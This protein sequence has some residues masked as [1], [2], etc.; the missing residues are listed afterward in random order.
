M[1]TKENKWCLTA[2]SVQSTS[3]SLEG[4]D[5]VH[6]SDGLSLGV[7]SVGDCI[8]DDI[9]QEHLQH[10]TSLL[11]DETADALHTATT[12]E[13]TDGWLGDSLDVIAKNLP[14]ALGASFSESFASFSTSRHYER[15]VVGL[16][17]EVERRKSDDQQ[18]VLVAFVESRLV[19]SADH[20][21]R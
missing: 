14:V 4:V 1:K 15:Y 10:S 20:I 19:E 13:T 17:L 11:I 18:S 12:S 7:L 9:L 6:G 3:L 8:T 2:K 16:F 21:G 5:N